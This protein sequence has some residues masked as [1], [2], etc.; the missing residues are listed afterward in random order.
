[1]LLPKLEFLFTHTLDTT[2]TNSDIMNH[3]SRVS[4]ITNKSKINYES[5][6]KW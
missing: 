6:V 2:Q 3:S 5:L 4:P 1:M